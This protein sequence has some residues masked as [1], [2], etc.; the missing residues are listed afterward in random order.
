MAYKP[1]IYIKSIDKYIGE[2]GIF[3]EEELDYYDIIEKEW[4][5][6]QPRYSFYQLIEIFPQ[7]KPAIKKQLLAE[8]KKCKDDLDAA[9]ELR[10]KFNNEI[11][12]RVQ[13]KNQWFFEMI[14]D[15]V[16]IEPLRESREKKI[17]RNY[18]Y[19]S[20]LKPKPKV[21]DNQNK[22]TDEDIQQAKEI[23]IET[24]YFGRLRKMGGNAVGL[25]PFHNEKT[26]SF[27][28]Y[29]N[30][31]KFYCFGCNAGTDAIDYVM[32]QYDCDFI[33]AVKKMLNK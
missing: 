28:I 20:A 31:N 23:P 29:L 13:Y 1:L 14:R 22:I 7:A 12:S 11:I 16:Y 27:T 5:A 30:Q 21:M 3:T 18:F 2:S 15:V 10:R 9:V 6:N 17:K 8:I 26:S 4:K 19:L 33:T 24:L 25:C 32:R